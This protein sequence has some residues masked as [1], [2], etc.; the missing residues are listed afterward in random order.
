MQLTDITA[1]FAPKVDAET[2]NS[3]RR[4][5]LSQQIAAVRR[6]S[7]VIRD[8]RIAFP[9]AIV[10]LALLN[11]G[12]ITVQTIINSMNLYSGNGDEQRM[13]NPLYFGQSDKGDRYRV[14]G[15]EAVRK[16]KDATFVTL[17]APNITLR[18]DTDRQTRISAANGVFDQN[19]KLFT[20]TGHVVFQSGSSDFSLYTEKAIVD[21]GKSTLY[22]DK[23]VVG[24]GSVGHIEAESFVIS[25][26]GNKAV[27]NGRGEAKAW[28]TMNNK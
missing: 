19:T 16:G 23:H 11:V 27:F 15:L 18:G 22:G 5:R 26:S 1:P 25:D 12:W 20:L 13:T 3:E 17:K 28:M 8:L 6:R 24:N 2:E 4:A 9:A 10:A 7:R 21:L 14:S